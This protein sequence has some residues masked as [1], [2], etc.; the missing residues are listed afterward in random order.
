M[1]KDTRVNNGPKEFNWIQ[2]GLNYTQED[3]L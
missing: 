3:Y 1:D 2:R